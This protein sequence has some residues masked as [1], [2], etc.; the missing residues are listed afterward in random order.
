VLHAV[1]KIDEQVRTDERLAK[2]IATL[3]KL[4]EQQ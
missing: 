1:R 3:I 4:V 2:D